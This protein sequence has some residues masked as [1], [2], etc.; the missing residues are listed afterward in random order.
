LKSLPRLSVLLTA[1]PTFLFSQVLH[2][3]AV[4]L[5]QAFLD[6]R[7]D[8]VLMDVSAHPDDEDGATLAFY[9]MQYGVRTYSVLFTR[10]EGGQ[11]ETG[12]ELYEDLGVLRS[13]E[14]E[15]A[16]RIL[17]TRVRFLNFLDF[18]FSKTATETFQFW[19]GQM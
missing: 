4:A 1:F 3:E 11:N 7:N 19:G 13:A 15:A 17:G 16:G 18:G 14:T 6:L 5:H 2:Q 9:R 12:P 10:G 8:S